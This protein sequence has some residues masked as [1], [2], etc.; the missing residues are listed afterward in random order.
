M[1]DYFN[2]EQFRGCVCEEALITKLHRLTDKQKEKVVK[3]I[4]SSTKNYLY[5]QGCPEDNKFNYLKVNIGNLRS[6]RTEYQNMYLQTG[7][8]DYFMNVL[9]INGTINNI[10]E[11]IHNNFVKLDKVEI[12][13]EDMQRLKNYDAFCE[14]FNITN[15]IVAGAV[16]E[17]LKQGA[18]IKELNKVCGVRLDTQNYDCEF[19]LR[20]YDGETNVRVKDFGES[21]WIK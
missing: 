11:Y 18:F 7:K 1:I 12:S 4:E 16:I 3:H 21:W 19:V 6:R 15:L 8:T 14:Q 2:E 13:N 5:M 10:K 17:A 20:T 9:I